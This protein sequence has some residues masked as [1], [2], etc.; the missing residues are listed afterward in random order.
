MFYY[1]NITETLH[2]HYTNH[3]FGNTMK[4]ICN[5]FSTF[6]NGIL[7]KFFLAFDLATFLL[8]P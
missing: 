6:G 5:C 1:T 7:S 3:L 8:D 4:R 2:K